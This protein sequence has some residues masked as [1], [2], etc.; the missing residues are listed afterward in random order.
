MCEVGIHNF[1]PQIDG[2]FGQLLKYVKHITS[3]LEDNLSLQ[4]SG[5]QSLEVMFK[6]GVDASLL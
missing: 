4:I 3:I 6:T 5:I 2:K 1:F